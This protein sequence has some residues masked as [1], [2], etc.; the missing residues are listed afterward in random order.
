MELS[1]RRFMQFLSA[2][3]VALAM[4]E[5]FHPHR[6]IFDMGKNMIWTPS[7]EK[8]ILSGEGMEL[9]PAFEES[10]NAVLAQY[11]ERIAELALQPGPIFL[12]LNSRIGAN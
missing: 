6:V 1:R 9:G 8:V 5:A 12:H 10:V 2:A 7:S 3:P 4:E 11:G